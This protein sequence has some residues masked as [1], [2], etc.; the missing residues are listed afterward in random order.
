[1]FD[2]VDS[3]VSILYNDKIMAENIINLN[4]LLEQW[5]KTMKSVSLDFK[6]SL[7]DDIQWESR[8]IGVRGARGTGKTTLLLQR[9]KE[10]SGSK[11]PGHVLYVSLDNLWFDLHNPVELADSFVKHGGTHL[12]LDEV[13]KY[14][15]WARALKNIYDRYSEL[16]VVF[17]GS[18]MLEILNSRADLSRRA[19]PYTLQGLSFREFINIKTK[20][21]LPAYTL[22]EI[23]EN[24]LEISQEILKK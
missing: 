15:N 16:S 11:N 8:L 22:Q 20:M 17:T 1:M 24:H 19:V 13:H 14:G 7:G 5:Q 21:A 2:A 18:S 6:R 12:F 9:A 4:P 3:F 10:L 23:L